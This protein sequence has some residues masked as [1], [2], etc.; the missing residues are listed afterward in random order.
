[1]ARSDA[2]TPEAYLE[3]LPE[4][5]AAV[6]AKVREVVRD[7]LPEG[8]EEAMAHGMI[9]YQIPLERYPD[10]YNGEPL[11]YV[12]LAAQKNHYALYMHGI[13][14]DEDAGRDFREGW[15]ASGKK[16]DMGKS[17]VR[18]KRL[19][20]VPLD[21]VAAAVAGCPVEDFLARYEAVKKR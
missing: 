14:M 21:V 4:D 1:M 6:V 15:E 19:E 2:A 3:E 17:C 13:Y 16:L 12:A 9:A 7:N 20:D 18:F 8:Y 10:T 11:M 5:R